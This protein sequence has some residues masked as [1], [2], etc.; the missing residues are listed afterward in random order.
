MANLKHLAALCGIAALMPSGRCQASER[1]TQDHD[2]CN[3][4]T[5]TY[6][7]AECIDTR[8]KLWDQRLNQAYR[9]ELGTLKDEPAR[10][11]ALR[12]AQRSWLRYRDDNCAFYETAAGTIRV[13]E[14][15]TCQ[16]DMTQDRAI[17]LQG[18]GLH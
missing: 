12:T 10:A 11:A 1:W 6:A 8:A 2:T 17:E 15:A 3:Q 14:V 5:T 13:I 7:I 4:Q 16:R 9:D 18:D